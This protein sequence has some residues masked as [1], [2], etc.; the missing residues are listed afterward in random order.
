MFENLTT[1]RE[2]IS[3]RTIYRHV[4]LLQEITYLEPQPD[5]EK[6]VL[7]KFSLF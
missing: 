3:N 7:S 1:H 5:I 4:N 2:R 6:P